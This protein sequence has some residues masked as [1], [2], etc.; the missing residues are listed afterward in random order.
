MFFINNT[1]TSISDQPPR[2]V[3]SPD[4]RLC[5]GESREA[6]SNWVL[7]RREAELGGPSWTPAAPVPAGKTMGHLPDTLVSSD[8]HRSD[9]FVTTGTLISTCHSHEDAGDLDR[10]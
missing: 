2:P 10:A 8:A 1:Y 9:T 7:G 4:F 5:L 6:S 3:D